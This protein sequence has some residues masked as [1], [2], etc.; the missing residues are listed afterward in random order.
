MITG[1]QGLMQSSGFRLRK[2]NKAVC[3]MNRMLGFRVFLL[4]V[5]SFLM[6]LSC[7]NE[8][9]GIPHSSEEGSE[10]FQSTQNSEVYSYKGE[11]LIWR[12]EAE[13]MYRSFKN[14]TDSMLAVPVLLYIFNE[15]RTDSTRILADSG[16]TNE[17]MNRFFIWGN[18]DIKKHDGMRIL[19]ESLWWDKERAEVGTDDYV[20]IM[21]PGGDV[22][23]G[24]GLESDE[25]FNA[26]SLKGEVSGRFPNFQKRRVGEERE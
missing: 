20:Q 6:F 11:N 2:S 3:A 15:E 14:G 23:R 19:S 17:E 5:L 4:F 16:I 10:P 25:N 8:D 7:N 9:Q 22:L 18:V 21:T 26:W 24:K 12:M 1:I 13:E